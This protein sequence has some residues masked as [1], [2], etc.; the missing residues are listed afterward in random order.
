MERKLQKSDVQSWKDEERDALFLAQNCYETANN[1]GASFFNIRMQIW[2]SASKL[3]EF[4]GKAVYLFTKVCHE[5]VR[6]CVHILEA[7]FHQ[8]AGK[9]ID[10]LSEAILITWLAFSN[11]LLKREPKKCLR[12]RFFRLKNINQCVSN[13]YKHLMRIVGTTAD[14]KLA[15]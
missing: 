3:H 6:Q 12:F 4:S 8:T 10:L 15:K 9:K 1:C 5:T 7:P 2:V 13:V 11:Y 14:R